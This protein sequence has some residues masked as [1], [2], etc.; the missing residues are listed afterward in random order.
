MILTITPNP[1]LDYIIH[2]PEPPAQGGHR[3]RFIDW[4]VGGKGINVA[5]MLKTL[6]RPALAMGFAGG[7]NGDK[8]RQRLREQGVPAL[9]TPTA[10]ETRVG[11]NTV[12]ERPSSQTW[13][14]EDGEELAESEILAFLETLE[15]QLP[16]TSFVAM[17]G[18][19]PGHGNRDLYRRVIERCRCHPCELYLDGRGEPLRQAL[20]A[21]G[22]FL[23][24][25]RDEARETFGIDPFDESC[26]AEF[27]ARLAEARVWGALITDGPRQALAWDPP[28]IWRLEPPPVREVSA[29]G[30]GDA[31]LAGLIWARATGLNWREAS[32][33]AMA[34][35]AADALHPGPCAASFSDIERMRKMLGA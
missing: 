5:R 27:F 2:A 17:S 33:W 15:T 23:K 9:L 8:I 31:A 26:T 3:C 10:A 30:S 24:H 11:I 34:A 19:I 21:G 1:L 35:G 29:V 28:H 12:I 32:L 16:K 4:T 20:Q 13:W 18:T 7:P 6:G 22:F 14:I 25:N